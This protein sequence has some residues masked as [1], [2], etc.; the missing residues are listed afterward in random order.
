MASTRRSRDVRIGTWPHDAT[1]ALITQRDHTVTVDPDDLH[2]AIAQARRDGRRAVRTSALL[3]PSAAVAAEMG[4]ECIDTLVLLARLIDTTRTANPRRTPPD[5]NRLAALRRWH[6]RR[7]AALDRAAFGPLWAMD[8]AALAAIGRA[9]P[10]HWARQVTVDTG[11]MAGFVIL[12]LGYR[13]PHEATTTGYLQRLSVDPDHQGRGLGGV[14]VDA[15]LS[16]L[17]AAG[18]TRVM[19]N[20]GVDNHR[21]LA[22]YRSFGFEPTGAQMSVWERRLDRSD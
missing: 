20:T 1:V 16:I 3:E 12:G 21:A 6:L 10:R 9:T 13:D 15:A 5:R 22:L 19:V 14:L 2:D 11:A 4:F 8:R 17:A 18:A 7:A